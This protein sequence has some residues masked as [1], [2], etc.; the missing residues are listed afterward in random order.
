MLVNRLPYPL[1]DGWKVRTFHLLRALARRSSVVVVCS[2]DVSP[3][4]FLVALGGDACVRS[5]QPPRRYTFSQLALGLVSRLPLY[6]H[7]EASRAFRAAAR[8]EIEKGCQVVLCELTAMYEHVRSLGIDDR[9]VID[10]HNID[11]IVFE[12]YARTQPTWLRRL[13]ARVTAAK[14]RAY[15][16]DVFRRVRAVIVCSDEESAHLET[17]VHGA[18]VWVVPNG[19]ELSSS[20]VADQPDP[21][22][23]FFFGRLDYHPNRDAME[24]FLEQVL[25]RVRSIRPSVELH[26]AGADNGTVEHMLAQAAGTRYYGRVKDLAPEL[27]ASALV[28]VP[29]RLGG[30]TRLKILEA[31]AAGRPVIS[32]TVGAE[33]LQV[34]D[35]LD[36]VLADDAESFAAAIVRLLEDPQ[37]AARI[38]AEGRR[39][40][41]RLYSWSALEEL[42]ARR[43]LGDECEG[44]AV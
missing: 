17:R 18:P 15:E 16:S 1:D 34:T 38:G 4:E 13:Y 14:M 12:R 24:Y 35:G 39:T 2:T 21:E 30:G 22:R 33:G 5:V 23:L 26:V 6:V 20:A 43:L 31:M 44:T 32:S 41:E 10:T 25:P 29:L 28:I 7:I 36:I 9:I 8:I 37:T 42:F 19:A 3:A 40:V 27:A 11:S